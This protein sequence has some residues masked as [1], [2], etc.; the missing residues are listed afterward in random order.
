[1]ESLDPWSLRITTTLTKPNI[2]KR[3]PGLV[4]GSFTFATTKPGAKNPRCPGPVPGSVHVR[5][6][7]RDCQQDTTRYS[8]E[9]PS[10]SLP[11][12]KPGVSSDSLLP[13]VIS[14]ERETPRDE[15][16]ASRIFCACC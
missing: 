5:H 4:P 2:L 14:G 10:V 6:S 16:G 12:D 1:V 3:C 15:P 9:V 11:R 13:A 7:V 8:A